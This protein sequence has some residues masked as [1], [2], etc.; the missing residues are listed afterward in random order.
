MTT[1]TRLTADQLTAARDVAS[2][3]ET[4]FSFDAYTPTGW[5]QCCVMLAERGY[6][7]R[8]IEAI[9]RS[10]WTRWA[11]DLDSDRRRYGQFNSATLARFIDQMI[12]TRG[13]ARV[14]TEIAELVAGTFND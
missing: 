4:A 3:T 6:G 1:K 14:D 13:K 11:G 10:K 12:D 5:R 7:P 8:E 9:M 2:R